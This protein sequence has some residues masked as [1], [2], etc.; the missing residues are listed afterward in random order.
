MLKKY[1][2]KKATVFLISVFSICVV[3][4]LGGVYFMNHRVKVIDVSNFNTQDAGKVTCKIESLDDTY[5]FISVSGYAFI[6]GEDIDYA[7]MQILICDNETGIYYA[8][9]TEVI[10]REDITR[11]VGDG[12]NYNYSG[13]SGAVYKS[14]CPVDGSLYILYRCNGNNILVKPELLGDQK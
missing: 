3:L 6:P 11:A 13:F 10:L 12:Y 9:P 4:F 5:D 7:A 14:K 8:I 2:E 1:E